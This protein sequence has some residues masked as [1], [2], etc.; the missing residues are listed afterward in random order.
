MNLY[1]KVMQYFWLSMAIV[2]TLGVTYL[3]YKEGFNRWVFYYTFAG[4]ALIMYFMKTMMMKRMAKH[5]EFLNS[6]R[7]ENNEKI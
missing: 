5:N 4:I 3:G 6:K 7:E 2:I 1:N